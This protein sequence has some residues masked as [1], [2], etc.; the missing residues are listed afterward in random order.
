MS[1]ERDKGA[2]RE[3]ALNVRLTDYTWH[4]GNRSHCTVLRWTYHSQSCALGQLLWQ[5]VCGGG[6][7]GAEAGGRSPGRR[8]LQFTKLEVQN[9]GVG[10]TPSR[11]LRGI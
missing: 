3:M 1:L 4:V 5:L 7:K 9:Q 2:R 11:G 10:N 8:W 6:L